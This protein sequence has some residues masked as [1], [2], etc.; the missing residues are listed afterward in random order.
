[1]MSIPKDFFD[2][3]DNAF[4]TKAEADKESREAE[5][6]S[7]EVGD[8]IKGIFLKVEFIETDYGTKPLAFIRDLNSD[9]Q[10]VKVWLSSVVLQEVVDFE[11]PAGTPIGIRYEGLQQ[12]K[13]GRD[14]KA[15][16]I[17]LPQSLDPEARQQGH[18]LWMQ[19]RATAQAKVDDA[20]GD[21]PSGG[22]APAMPQQ[23]G[24][25]SPF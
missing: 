9:N 6:W 2:D 25:M 17:V 21:A 11:P 22:A 19:A 4:D 7:P 3:M 5:S 24:D 23:T 1:M 8:S 13:S 18:Q 15:Y 16:T 20:F 14:F 12:A 10:T